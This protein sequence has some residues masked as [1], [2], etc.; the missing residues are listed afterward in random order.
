M[1]VR[2]TDGRCDLGSTEV[3]T[4]CVWDVRYTANKSETNKTTEFT[5]V[6]L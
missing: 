1:T 4:E 6:L 2:M 5:D 3:H